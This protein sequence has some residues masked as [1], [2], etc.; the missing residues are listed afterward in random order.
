MFSES[1]YWAMESARR[2]IGAYV[3][4]KEALGAERPVWFAVRGEVWRP[5]DVRGEAEG[6]RAARRRRF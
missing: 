5:F 6:R 1:D 4:A 3:A 2:L